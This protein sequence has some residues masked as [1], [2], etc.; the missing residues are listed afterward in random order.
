M[1]TTVAAGYTCAARAHARRRAREGGF[2]VLGF[3]NEDEFERRI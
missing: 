2:Y 3:S 1:P